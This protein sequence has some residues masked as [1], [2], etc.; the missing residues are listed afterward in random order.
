MTLASPAEY[1]SLSLLCAGAVSNVTLRL[2]IQHQDSLSNE[3]HTVVVRDWTTNDPAAWVAYGGV[4]LD[5]R[6]LTNIAN[7]IYALYSVD[8]P[9]YNP[10]SPITGMTVTWTK[11][12]IG[13]H[14]AIFAVSGVA[15]GGGGSQLPPFHITSEQRLSPTQFMIT[16]D[17][18]AGHNYQ[19]L[20]AASPTNAWITNATVAATTAST[21]YTD[22]ILANSTN[23][24]YRVLG[25][26]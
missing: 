22:T 16:W 5:N 7:S 10:G 9:V 25:N 18:V 1:S 19:V 13:S 12:K 3:V 8:V 26:P 17:S 4:D 2:V 21:A 15:V 20:S 11:G 6:T 24:F 23:K 14:A